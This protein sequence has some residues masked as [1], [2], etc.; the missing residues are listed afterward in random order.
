[1]SKIL[2]GGA[3]DPVPADPDFKIDERYVSS[4]TEG[5]IVC[6]NGILHVVDRFVE[7]PANISLVAKQANLSILLQI[8]NTTD[9]L[10]QVEEMQNI[11]I[12]AAVG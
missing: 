7:I 1:M 3:A 8:L 9:L 11:T 12:F 4:V 10:T 5:D 6:T 2:F